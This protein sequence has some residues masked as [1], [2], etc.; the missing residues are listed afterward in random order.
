M[1]LTGVA[2]RAIDPGRAA[3]GPRLYA[4]RAMDP[5]E[6][7]CCQ[8]SVTDHLQARLV[9]AARRLERYRLTHVVVFHINGD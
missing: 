6:F 5:G 8:V 2:P 7:H 1:S 4:P 3:A 9:L